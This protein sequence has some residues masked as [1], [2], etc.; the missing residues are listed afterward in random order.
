MIK[1][2]INKYVRYSSDK[3]KWFEELN[4][5]EGLPISEFLK[6][7]KEEMK[8]NVD[9]TQKP[10]NNNHNNDKFEKKNDF[11]ENKS[12]NYNNNGGNNNYN[13]TYN[14]NNTFNS[15][16]YNNSNNF[17]N[18]Y[19]NNENNNQKFNKS[20][21]YN[22]I[23]SKTQSNTNQ[24]FNNES[25]KENYN[26][27][28]VYNSYKEKKGFKNNSN[29]DN[30]ENNINNNYGNDNF[31]KNNVTINNN[32][33]NNPNQFKPKQED[34]IDIN[35]ID[36]DEV[37]NFDVGE[38][39]ETYID[40]N[41]KTNYNNNFGKNEFEEN[42]NFENNKRKL[43]KQNNVFDSSNNIDIDRNLLNS[44]NYKTSSRKQE[45]KYYKQANKDDWNKEF[46]WTLK[47]GKV[48]LKY[49]AHTDFRENQLEIINASMSKR[50]IFVCM[51]TGGGKSLTYQIPAI[52]SMGVTLVI[53]PLVSLIL[54]QYNSMKA[55]DIP[56]LSTKEQGDDLLARELQFDAKGKC[57]FKIILTTPEK[58]VRN[59]KFKL[60][61]HELYKDGHL[62]RFVIDEAHCL[63]KW[64]ND[65]RKDYLE[66]K[67]LRK[68]FRTVPILALTATAPQEVREDV[69]E[70]LGFNN[71]L[72][73][74]QSY[75]RPNLKII[76]NHKKDKDAFIEIRD[77]VKNKFGDKSGIIY[78][79][80]KD[81]CEELTKKLKS[82]KINCA[83]YHAGMEDYARTQV[84]NDWKNDEIQIIVATCAFGMGINKNDV[85]FV[86]HQSLPSSYE[87]YYQEI[88]RAGRDGDEA[89]CVLYY[90]QNDKKTLEYLQKN[91]P[92]INIVKKNYKRINQILEFCEDRFICRK[93]NILKYF[94]EEFNSKNCGEM[95][96]NCLKKQPYKEVDYKEEAVEI[97]NFV[98]TLKQN[99][100]SFTANQIALTL[101]GKANKLKD[102][103][104]DRVKDFIGKLK[105]LDE[106]TLKFLIRRLICLEYLNEC[107]IQT[108]KNLIILIE[109]GSSYYEDLGRSK[110]KFSFSKNIILL[111]LDKDK[112]NKKIAIEDSISNENSETEDIFEMSELKSDNKAN[113]KTNLKKKTVKKNDLSNLKVDINNKIDE[114]EEM[115]SDFKEYLYKTDNKKKV[116]KEKGADEYGYLKDQKLFE[117]LVG[118][119]RKERKEILKK[120]I[121]DNKS[122]KDDN[123]N[124]DKEK[125]KKLNLNDIF[126]DNGLKELA[127]KLPTHENQLTSSRIYGV[128][129]AMLT[130]YGPLFLNTIKKFL[131]VNKIKVDEN[132][133]DITTNKQISNIKK[134]VIEKCS[135]KNDLFDFLDSNEDMDDSNN[136]NKKEK[137]EK[138][139]KNQQNKLNC[140]QKED[141]KKENKNDVSFDIDYDF[142]KNDDFFLLDHSFNDN[143]LLKEE[144]KENISKFESCKIANITSTRNNFE[145]IKDNKNNACVINPLS[146]YIHGNDIKKDYKNTSFDGQVKSKNLWENLKKA[147][148]KQKVEIEKINIDKVYDNSLFNIELESYD[149]NQMTK[150]NKYDN[151]DNHNNE[152]WINTGKNNKE[153]QNFAKPKNDIK[154]N[155]NIE[156]IN[157]IS[158]ENSEKNNQKEKTKNEYNKRKYE[159]GNNKDDCN[160][161]DS[162][163][164]KEKE[165]ESEVGEESEEFGDSEDESNE[166]SDNESN[167]ELKSSNVNYNDDGIIEYN[168]INIEEEIQI[169][170]EED[171]RIYYENLLKRFVELKKNKKKKKK[172]D[173]KDNKDNKEIEY[174][175]K[176]FNNASKDDIIKLEAEVN[177]LEEKALK[178][179]KAEAFFKKKRLRDRFKKNKGGNGGGNKFKKK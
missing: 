166:N 115:D 159:K 179:Q 58:V 60:L 54:D 129:K 45:N 1:T 72:F 106:E 9:N 65:F 79:L 37:F 111:K 93:K 90:N 118:L 116:K 140:Q 89:D 26:N 131:E 97:I 161:K 13:K 102:G 40:K 103:K 133:I 178:K 78:C 31:N 139:I 68:E 146:E 157:D 53:M 168:D 154:I 177:S 81:N 164:N 136:I 50:D 75:N 34:K 122:N 46:S 47:A 104:L 33:K 52:L 74:K 43:P 57:K 175:P 56:V 10:T 24:Y 20:N 21:V 130:T 134:S 163:N 150:N 170:P 100:N 148:P 86:I 155:S 61:L 96:D 77:I 107:P 144:K 2:N 67:L 82:V 85:R 17:S 63:S 66:L 62:E 173:K 30:N 22:N 121:K 19:N 14:N 83:F 128:G 174:V 108:G 105:Q 120:V 11:Y 165:N 119:L 162:E 88:G 7:Y 39:N 99:G 143:K 91:V 27:F 142:Y 109:L 138:K 6:K 114:T 124:I 44:I 135:Q 117:E 84:Q 113:M 18:S 126:T 149:E 153:N 98:Q 169:S 42:F 71:G 12:N 23:S 92:D 48:L 147:T 152:N 38:A 35:S 160:I 151:Y 4:K 125:E 94:D 36:Y 145:N 73:F 51:P 5:S 3:E 123:T 176:K 141:K 69:I 156:N 16:S 172:K 15:N 95:C 25:N 64:G 101:V 110:L 8:K 80:T 59:H 70:K 29:Y 132:M 87:N 41:K 76:I 127:K 32:Y 137:K 28:N 112:K 171:K 55:I 49:F 158:S 167:D